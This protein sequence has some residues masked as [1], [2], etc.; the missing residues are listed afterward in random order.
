MIIINNS[1]FIMNFRKFWKESFVGFV[2]KRIILAIIIFISL[3]WVTLLLIDK[4]TNHG[5]FEIVPDLR[6]M[7]LEEAELQLS[8]LELYPQVIDSFYVKNKKLGT[9]LEQTPVAGSTIKQNRPIYIIVNSRQVR[10]IPM[11]EVR[12]ISYRQADV[13]LKA[14]GINV[15]N[16]EYAPSEY[17]DL[18]IDVKYRGASLVSGTRIPEGSFLVLV[19]GS[20][21]NGDLI[22]VPSLKGLT[23]ENAQNKALETSVI[24][25]AL[26][27]DIEPNGN[28]QDYVI[29]KQK[30]LAGSEA[31]A[32]RRIDVWLSKDKSLL[33]QNFNEGA[34][35]DD[36]VFF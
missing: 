3:G 9:I 21:M 6:G 31:D 19:V 14:I 23:L 22:L 12:D 1:H 13:M 15:S 8:N 27:Y 33:N 30:P 24:V 10:Q 7:Y 26:H 5:Q 36:E 2:L 4:Y 11:P 16:V 20:G 17:K 35:V 18:V 28:E 29:Y 34:E 25:G 32:G